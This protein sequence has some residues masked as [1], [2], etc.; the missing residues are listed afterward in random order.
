MTNAGHADELKFLAGGG[1]SGMQLRTL[2]WAATPIGT[3]GG[4]PQSLRTAVKLMLSTRHPVS[5]FWGTDALHLF[6]DAA[7]QSFGAER[8]A[9]AMAQ[10]GAVVWTE[11]WDVIGPQF[12][13]VMAGG[14]ATWHENQLVPITRDGR[15]E[16]VYWTYSYC[17]ID[18]PKAPN[19]VGGVLVIASETTA[20][21]LAEKRRAAEAQRQRTLFEQAPGFVIIMR[22]PEHVV[23]FVNREHRRLFN[24]DSWTGKPIRVAFP[25]I[26]GQGFFDLLDEVFATGLTRRVDAAP[27][28]YRQPDT[29]DEKTRYLDFIYAPFFDAEGR[30]SGVFCEG[31]DVTE[32]VEAAADLLSTEEQLR[33]A[34][35]AA[36][37]GWWD[38][39]E[40]HGR[41]IWP[42]RVKAMFGI[43]PD[44]PVSM[45]D[46][47]AGLHPDD[48]DA[49]A[50]TYA[51]AADPARRALYDVE[52]R[53]IGKEDG[54][55]RWVAA[56]GRGVFDET[57]RCVRVIGT[58]IDITELKRAQEER[59]ARQME[60]AELREQF[61]AVLGHD[62]RN[63]LASV[64]AGTRVLLNRP[65]RAAEIAQ[66]IERSITRMSELIENVLDFAR[67]RLG[68][69][70][71]TTRDSEKPLEPVLLQVIDE[72]REVH[73]ERDV[74]VDIDLQEPVNCDRQRIGQLLS[75]LLG[76]A[77]V[78]GAP[79][80]PIKIRARAEG[81]QFELCV[82][83]S[84]AP[85]EPSAL[86]RLFQPFFR[87]KVRGSREGLGLGLYICA[88]VAKAHG[89]T[90][91]VTSNSETTR[92]TLRMP[93]DL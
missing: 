63:P 20:T 46:F 47:Y 68:G 4:W 34:T 17:P 81:G 24:S 45:D 62:L 25:D 42:P 55:Q 88:E 30:M 6:N 35:E 53:T 23:E 28:R 93:T 12:E 84:G 37:I 2:D 11:I 1:L 90:I 75:N 33:L 32:R 64:A 91:D 9:A 83:N 70:F 87:G 65:E 78:Y 22:G 10:P 79:T 7:G 82:A 19:E 57:G 66:H 5:I 56:K 89:G 26:S 13:Q 69:G 71:V 43:S 50:A 76:N 41:L 21:V 86:T 85:I 52:Y 16:D 61:I 58:A 80:A 67:G 77:L 3:P 8:R 38:V 59:L 29:G 14:P 48:R 27:A 74:A 31:F 44:A 72:L 92:F 15:L 49:V 73:P 39:E 60:D 36:D 51:G 54:V 40:G 18:D